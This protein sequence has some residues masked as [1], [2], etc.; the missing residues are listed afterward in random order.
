MIEDDTNL[1]NKYRLNYHCLTTNNSQQKA[2]DDY[3]KMVKQLYSEEKV[4]I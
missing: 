1:L 4:E 2:K 3:V